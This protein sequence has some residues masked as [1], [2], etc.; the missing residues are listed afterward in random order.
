MTHRFG[1][2]ETVAAD[3]GTIFIGD[4]VMAFAQQFGITFWH[5]TPFY[6]QTNGKAEATNKIIIEL[7]KKNTEDKLGN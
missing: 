2:Y 3:Q 6:S 4:R 7:I 1:I 5:S